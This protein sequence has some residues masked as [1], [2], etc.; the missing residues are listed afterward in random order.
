[1]IFKASHTKDGL[2]KVTSNSD[3]EAKICVK[4]G[5]SYVKIWVRRVPDTGAIRSA[6]AHWETSKALR[7]ELGADRAWER[8]CSPFRGG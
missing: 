6:L 2:A 4:L 1:M 3:I 7:L 8:S 5:T